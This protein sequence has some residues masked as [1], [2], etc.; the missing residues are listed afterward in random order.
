[1]LEYLPAQYLL[2][3]LCHFTVF[4]LPDVVL[5]LGLVGQEEVLACWQIASS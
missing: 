4:L 5:A 3:L 2:S 1:V